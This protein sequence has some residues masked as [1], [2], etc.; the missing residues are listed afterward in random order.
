M[1]AS[2]LSGMRVVEAAAFVAAPLGGMTLAQMGADVI[3]IDAVG[4]GLDYHRWPVAPGGTSLFWTGLNRGKRSVVLDLTAP[5]GRE[6]A[7]AIVCAP[8]DDAGLF[9]TNFPPRGWLDHDKL[10]AKRPD[11]IQLT[12]QGD[13]HGGS[14]VD[15]TVNARV[16]VPYLTGPRESTGA[17]NHV[18][19]A[20]D[21]VTGHLV[22]VGLL[23][24]ERH[25][26]R[27]GQG[28]HVKLALEDVALAVMAH[29]G[30]ITEAELGQPRGRHGNDLFGA[31]G[32]DFESADGERV[33]LVGLTLKQWKSIVQ[34]CGIGESVKELEKRLGADL[35]DEGERFRHRDQL[36]ALIAPWVGARRLTELQSALDGAGVCWGRYQDIATLTRDDPSCSPANPMFARIEQPGVG[37][38][39]APGT[40]LQFEGLERLPPAPAPRLGEHTEQVLTDLLGLSGSEFG[41]LHD[42]RIVRTASPTDAS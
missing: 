42:R 32:R 2:P 4:G 16:G 15:Y 26:I 35:S 20:W 10:R 38:V 14:A 17:V 41:R 30:F 22:A 6:L 13:R 29:L 27:T 1:T 34:A 33:M 3:R 5:E 39:L 24:A 19:P 23:A 7:T 11:L 12:L 36:A 25:R 18:L 9:L 8:G 28:R 21:L 40:P 37:R 31:F